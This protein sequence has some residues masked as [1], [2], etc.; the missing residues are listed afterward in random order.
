M[1]AFKK[2]VKSALEEDIGHGD[3]TTDSLIKDD[4]YA[5]AVVSA[6]ENMIVAGVD[7]VD[8]VLHTVD[9]EIQ[10]HSIVKNGDTVKAGD[11]I[12]NIKGKACSILKAERTALNFLM[13]LSGIATL[14]R[15]YVN[16]IHGSGVILLD[17]RKTTPGIRIF[18][19]YA[20]RIGGGTNHRF[21]LFDGILIKDNHL[22]VSENISFAV[23]KAKKSQP[24][25]RVEVEVK[26]IK[27]LKKAID[28]KADIVLLDNMDLKQLKEAIKLAKGKVLIEV[29]GNVTLDNIKGIAALKPDFISCGALTHS[30]RAIDISMKITNFYTKE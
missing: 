19:K 10:F 23:N 9:H 7:I 1:N 21:G 5:D 11:T 24:L 2:L 17:T 28:A 29:S 8:I 4:V 22:F 30:A 3:I 27:E 18:E 14:T 12:A 13:H 6:K 20:V 25:K 26:S 16:A 15:T